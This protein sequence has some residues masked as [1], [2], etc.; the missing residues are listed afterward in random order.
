MPPRTPRSFSQRACDPWR[1]AG[2]EC[3]LRFSIAV[4]W[5]RP[6]ALTPHACYSSPFRAIPSTLP[7]P[8]FH[9]SSCHQIWSAPSLADV[10]H[11]HA[12]LRWSVSVL[13]A[14][15]S[16]KALHVTQIYSVLPARCSTAASR[17]PRSSRS[18]AHG[19][20][21]LG[22]HQCCHGHP[23]TILALP[24]SLAL[25]VFPASRRCTRQ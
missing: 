5:P 7:L 4:E 25:L 10:S 20:G 18:R 21:Q 9:P 17:A 8:S 15:R 24:P 22:A 6:L 1:R 13:P 19:H 11:A 16:K 23:C 2:R 3:L 12:R 14:G